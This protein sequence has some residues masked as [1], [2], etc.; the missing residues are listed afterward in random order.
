[1]VTM[2][3]QAF[4][5]LKSY[6]STKILRG[7]KKLQKALKKIKKSLLAFKSFKQLIF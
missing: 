6:F 5:P 1:M 7:L 4:Q 2:K 3:T